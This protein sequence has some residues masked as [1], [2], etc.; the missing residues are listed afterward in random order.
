[1]AYFDFDGTHATFLSLRDAMIVSVRN[2]QLSCPYQKYNKKNS[3]KVLLL[4]L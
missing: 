3:F 2:L 4:Q 1:M